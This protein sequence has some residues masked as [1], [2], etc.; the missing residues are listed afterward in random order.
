MQPRE[1]SSYRVISA[2]PCL[3]AL[4]NNGFS[5]QRSA[6]P[7][8][9]ITEV[10]AAVIERPGGTFLLAQRPKGKPYAGYWEFPGGKIEPG[11]DARA[12]L[13]RELREEL[14]IEVRASS[15]WITRVYAYTHARVRLHFFKVTAWDGEPQRLEDQDI[16]WQRVEAPDVSPMLPAN[17]PVLAALALPSIMIV[18]NCAELGVDAWIQKVADLAIG[19]KLL[20]QVRE[21]QCNFQQVQHILSRA[22]ARTGP[23]G[24]RIV[25][26]SDC[27]VFPQCNGVHLTAKALMAAI[28]RPEAA[29]VGASCHDERELDHAEKIGVDYV[30]VGPVTATV[31]HP[32]A[33]P[34]G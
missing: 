28:A 34:L 1:D 21:K 3:S 11:E 8:T 10:A 2:S 32:G 25:V 5:E 13:T 4:R 12:A 16:K 31:S 29:L 24:A 9:K 15:P 33:A 7:M 26:N 17:A 22:L 20:V 14:G 18:S 23:F 6:D 30:V 27:G 19:E